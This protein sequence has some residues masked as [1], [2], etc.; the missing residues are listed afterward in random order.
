MSDKYFRMKVVPG[1]RILR[2]DPFECLISFICSQNNNIPRIIKNV[3]AVR[4]TFGEPIA[5]KYDFTW[6]SFPSFDS[7]K[8]AEP[9]KMGTLG[10][11]YRSK[12]I[13]Q[14]M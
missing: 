5:T 10:L 13:T 3:D 4:T 9:A 7:L 6:H 2:Q 8:D 11:G 12:Y 1:V 14:T